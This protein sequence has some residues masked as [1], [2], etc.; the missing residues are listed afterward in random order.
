MF[1]SE[2]RYAISIRNFKRLSLWKGN[3]SNEAAFN[4]HRVMI[5]LGITEALERKG[6]QGALSPTSTNQEWRRTWAKHSSWGYSLTT[7]TKSG[8]STGFSSRD[9]GLLVDDFVRGV[10]T[11]G[12]Y[13]GARL[14]QYDKFVYCVQK[15]V[16]NKTLYLWYT[17]NR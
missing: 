10:L 16:W 1:Q 14:C 6:L 5:R 17:L 15:R 4:T 11:L 12:L 3:L 9:T 2:K 8:M 7:S 13:R